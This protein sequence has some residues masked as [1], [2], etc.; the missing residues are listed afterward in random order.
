MN[1]I[2]LK[3]STIGDS[4]VRAAVLDGREYRFVF[5]TSIAGDLTDRAD[6]FVYALVFPM[7]RVGGEFKICGRVSRSVIDNIAM[8]CR[9]WNIW[10]PDVYKPIVIHADEVADDWRPDNRKLIT[11]FSGGLDAA[12]TAYKY[13]N[14]LDTRF[15]YEYD[16]SVMILGADIPLTARDQFAAAFAAAKR[17]TDDLG[18]ELIPVETNYREYEHDWSYEFGAV[19]AAVLSFF[20]RT[21][22]YGAAASDDSFGVFETPWG[23]NPVS[24][25]FLSSDT[26]RFIT[27]GR[28]HTRTQ[29]AAFIKDWAVGMDNL[30]VCWRNADKS[31][32][33]GICEK[34]VRT[35]LNFLAV[36]REFMP[37]M[38]TD[39]K[40]DELCASGLIT[41]PH[42]VLYYQEIYDYAIRN[43]TLD[44]KWQKL[45]RDRIAYW[46]RP[47]RGHS[48]WWHIRHMKF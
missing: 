28:E 32:N 30:R 1:E 10:C 47:H 25:V 9:I 2:K 24:D 17:M 4:I 27:D 20:G 15:T 48:F 38:P 39:I 33:C 13:K 44:E 19:V 16:K 46:R 14:N 22:F 31:K 12:Y 40:P 18:V 42:N 36:G 3:T 43:G 34:C 45:L 29:R 26:F 8:F 21:Y 7:M 37:T 11:A 35:K 6:P 5:P 23:T 41:N